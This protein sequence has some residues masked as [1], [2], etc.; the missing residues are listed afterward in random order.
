MYRIGLVTPAWPGTKT[1]NGI[2]TS[3][4]NLARGLLS[5]GHQPCIIAMSEDGPAPPDIPMVA[6]SRK[7]W[8]FKDKVLHKLGRKD[9]PVEV[10]SERFADAVEE[11]VRVHGLNFLLVEETQG[12]ARRAI[13]RNIVPVIVVLH[14]PWILHRHIQ[15]NARASDARRL[16][17]EAA[18][19]RAAAGILAPSRNVLEAVE[20]AV[21]LGQTPRAIIPNA[22]SSVPSETSQGPPRVLFVGRFD[23]HK[24]GDTV[25]DAFEILRRTQ[26]QAEL[27]FVGPDRGVRSKNG[28]ILWLKEKLAQMSHDSRSA[29]D[30]LGACSAQEIADLRKTH[31]IAVI[32][33]RYENYPYAMLEAMAA[34]Q[35]IVSTDVGGLAEVLEDGSTALLVPPRDPIA[36]AQALNELYV[37]PDKV[38]KLGAAARTTAEQDLL[39][40]SVASQTVEFLCK[41]CPDRR[42]ELRNV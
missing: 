4:R 8:D 30:V 21:P 31:T 10:Q 22:I 40:E 14:G 34:G 1:P 20:Q 28:E 15:F 38:Y 36:M 2:C 12:L 39:P 24:G 33:S 9:V 19:F 35:A 23:F 25:L 11:A 17:R 6:V 18:L 27:T 26:P 37:H 29:I 5:I 16:A 7:P 42:R 32:A 3:V 13:A 41:L